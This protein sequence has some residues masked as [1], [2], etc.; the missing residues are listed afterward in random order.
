MIATEADQAT[1]T[2]L[3]ASL[4]A[5]WNAGSGD[6]FAA[7]FAEDADFVNIFGHYGKGRPAIAEA[8]NAIFRTVY[9]GSR[10]A[11]T[12]LRARY[13]TMDVALMH[14]DA[15]L[16]IPSGPMVGEKHSIPSLVLTRTGDHWKIASFHNTLIE[17]P[18]REHNNG[19]TRPTE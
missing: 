9:A 11:Y 15:R 16:R 10:L 5:A 6:G 1:W 14:L 19:L 8:H 4:E 2:A 12:V 3:A 18:P 17:E 7:H 13:L